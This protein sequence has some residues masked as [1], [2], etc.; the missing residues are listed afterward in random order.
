MSTCAALPVALTPSAPQM[1]PS[2]NTTGQC[3]SKT[4]LD[5]RI[6]RSATQKWSPRSPDL[7][8]PHTWSHTKAI[9][10]QTWRNRATRYEISDAAR[11]V[12]SVAFQYSCTFPTQNSRDASLSSRRPSWTLTDYVNC[13][14]WSDFLS[15]YCT[16]LYNVTCHPCFFS[17]L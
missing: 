3:L 12:N 5:R 7:G 16:V 4:F 8:P 2:T 14:T 13:I 15:M 9:S 11:R 17:A 6:G 10:R 1:Q